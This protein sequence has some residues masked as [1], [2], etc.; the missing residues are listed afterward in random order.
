MTPIRTCDW[1]STLRDPTISVMEDLPKLMEIAM[2]QSNAE[3]VFVIARRNRVALERKAREMQGEQ[4]A[5]LVLGVSRRL[6]NG[7]RALAQWVRAR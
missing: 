7:A 3:S 5:R 6:A 2:I 1:T 4:F